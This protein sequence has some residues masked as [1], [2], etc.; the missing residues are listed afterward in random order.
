MIGTLVVRRRALAAFAAFAAAMALAAGAHGA[1]AA[2]RASADAAVAATAPAN[3]V[4]LPLA[5]QVERAMKAYADAAIETF[6]ASTS[7]RERW[8]GGMMLADKALRSG[9]SDEAAAALN[10]RAQSLF[11]SA[12]AQAGKD[13][14]LLFWVM[15]DPPVRGQSDS[16]AMAE[17]R[18]AVLAELQKL[19]PDNAVVWLASLP[20]RD[21]PGSIPMAIEMLAR[22][23]AAK[24]FDTHF[25]AS[26]RALLSAFG[27]VPLP[28]GWP[29]T[30]QLKGWEQVEAADVQVIMAVGVSSA[31]AMPYLVGLQ[32][33]CDGNSAEHPWL[34]DCRKLARS[35]T[36]RSDSI[37]PHSLALA[38]TGKLHGADSA[39]AARAQVQR[40]E[41]A[42]LIENGLQRVGPGQPV[43]FAEWRR[44][45]MKPGATELSVS[46]AMLAAQGLPATPPEDF[47]PAWDR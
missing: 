23:A 10:A 20:A 44:A 40:R 1:E 43:T 7:A 18:L 11:D 15:F 42:W 35:M 21:Q 29:D 17:A 25:A 22:A 5:Q 32:W 3:S 34:P 30:R 47:V 16:Q 4:E 41:L 13:P 14:T 37:V 26:M 24:R 45:W 31:M 38:L 2:P 8:I 27:R 39:E 9:A 28:I 33:W 6:A 46:R 12:R 36:E 19:E